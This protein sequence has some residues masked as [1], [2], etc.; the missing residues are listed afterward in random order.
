M[1]LV[2]DKLFVILKDKSLKKYDLRKDKVLGMAALEKLRKNEG[3]VDTRTI[4]KLCAYLDCQP[5]DFMEY[6]PDENMS[7]GEQDR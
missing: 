7:K 6:I 1:P 5:G 2:Y 3:H 4:E